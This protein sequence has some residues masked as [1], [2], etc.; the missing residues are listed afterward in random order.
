METEEKEQ[1]RAQLNSIIE[2]VDASRKARD[3]GEAEYEGEMMDEDQIREYMDENIL[4]L[5]TRSGW[6]APSCEGAK[7]EEFKI[8]LCTGGPAVQIIGEL[9]EHLEPES[10]KIQY[11]DWFTPWKDYTATDSEEDEKL[12]EYCQSFY[13]GE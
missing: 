6:G 8:L 2:M 3:E 1:A 13:Y 9:N 5:E 4:S 12:L 10:A 7:A 11:Q